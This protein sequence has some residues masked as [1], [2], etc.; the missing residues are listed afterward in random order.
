MSLLLFTTSATM[1]LLVLLSTLNPGATVFTAAT[2]F[3]AA[4][5]PSFT[6]ARPHVEID[7]QSLS[8]ALD[9]CGPTGITPEISLV[10]PGA[11]VFQSHIDAAGNVQR[12]HTSTTPLVS[13]ITDNKLD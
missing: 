11:P 5:A 12:V 7:P 13:V 10:E 3:A 6:T 1:L 9:L 4:T 8:A 2:P